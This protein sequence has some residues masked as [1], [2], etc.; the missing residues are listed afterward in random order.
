M[1]DLEASVLIRVLDAFTGPLRKFAAGLDNTKEHADRLKKSFQLS[2]DLNQ[3][4][5]GMGRFANGLIGP[6]KHAVT[7][8][9]G[10]EREMSKV[11]ALSGEIGTEGF[12]QM[13]MQ[14]LELGA[15]TAYSSEEAAQ[16]MAQY[17]QAGRTVNEILAVT[18]LT[19]AAAKANGTGLA[20]TAAIIGHTMSGMGIA[21][22][23]TAR[24]V[25]VLTA[26][27]A[28]SDMT[29]GDMG[30]ALAYV[31][32]VAR[33]AGMSLELT[34][35]FMGKMKDAGLEASSVGTGLRA[36]IARL[37][38]PSREATKAF[39]S[40]GIHTKQLAELQKLAASG[41]ADEALRRIGTAA[42]KLPNE[43]RMK[44]LSQIFGLEASTAANVA[45]TASMDVSHKGL[46]ALEESLK[47]SSGTAERL[48]GVMEDNLGGSME[49]ASGAISGLSTKVGEVLKPTVEAGATAVETMAG[50]LT[51]WVNE[52][53]KAAKA[54]LELT[55]SVAA[56]A[57]VMKGG[58]LAVSAYTAATASLG[59]TYAL[60][61][62]SAVGWVFAA[63]AA[64]AAG[65][66]IGAWAEETF[67]LANKISGLLG[68][69]GPD[70]RKDQGL[71]KGGIEEYADGTQIDT[72]G[73]VVKLGTKGGR[74]PSMVRAAQAAGAKTPEEI[75]N[76]IRGGRADRTRQTF[77]RE[78]ANGNMIRT[79]S[80]NA[81]S[82]R[83]E[84][85]MASKETL[86]A[87][88]DQTAQVVASLRLNT[89]ASQD[90]L[91]EQRRN[92]RRLS[93]GGGALAGE[94]AH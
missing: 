16:A 44:M 17:A 21:T 84:Q 90:L 35:A 5:E 34:A 22:S 46:R 36:T 67:D 2:A 65:Y 63:A 57:L 51:E 92:R 87:I 45:I 74:A 47:K 1:A 42:E 43:Q 88:K 25:D 79:E 37:L 20:E 31:G 55:A 19:L 4:A 26:G 23:D 71:E 72:H 93:S 29:L 85:P 76:F 49:R 13:R 7:E 10:F 59:K 24:V 8:F 86:A 54:S 75:S 12:E 81:V 68:R 91:D 94:G 58:L 69:A 14:A 66:A 15:A 6:L 62:G 40:L 33:Q 50:K 83:L 38:D 41:K 73:N 27:A 89:Q 60:M 28:A 78:R 11:S 77:E 61:S 48:A 56:L 30:Q 70:S 53:P 39:A 80:F 3:S 9:I 64:G 18:P 52:N 82:G 32:P